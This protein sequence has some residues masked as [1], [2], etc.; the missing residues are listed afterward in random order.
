[1]GVRSVKGPITELSSWKKEII[2]M[3]KKYFLSWKKIAAS[4]GLYKNQ[5]WTTILFTHL[6]TQREDFIPPVERPINK[7]THCWLL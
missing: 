1:M 2:F 5:D 3:K 7:F 4:K 6:A